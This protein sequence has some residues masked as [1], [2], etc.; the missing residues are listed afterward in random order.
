MS[1]NY[2]NKL[3]LGVPEENDT[4]WG[5]SVG[6]WADVM[7]II[8]TALLNRNYVVSG[9]NAY[10]NAGNLTFS[11]DSG[12]VCVSGNPVFIAGGAASLTAS[13]H[14]WVYSYGS[15]I[16]I[17]TIMPTGQFCPLYCILTSSTGAVATADLRPL[18]PR[19]NGVNLSPKQLSPTDNCYIAGGKRIYHNDSGV[20]SNIKMWTITEVEANQPGGAILLWEDKTAGIDWATVN[21]SAIV[22]ANAKFA[23]VNTYLNTYNVPSTGWVNFRLTADTTVNPYYFSHVDFGHLGATQVTPWL[24]SYNSKQHLIP[25]G[26]GK[27][28]YAKTEVDSLGAGKYSAAMTLMGYIE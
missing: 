27:K 8:G 17:S 23:I 13:T 24:T 9:F 28:L 19:A 26:A 21:A 10:T 14:N 6:H 11:Y 4:N 12:T 16:T 2:T 22:S 18:Y 25:F 3:K 5:S 15:S 1:I 20:A 7:E